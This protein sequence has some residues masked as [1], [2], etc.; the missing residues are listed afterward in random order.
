VEEEEQL[1]RA[2]VVRRRR[3]VE[4]AGDL[5]DPLHLFPARGAVE[6]LVERFQKR[7]E[8]AIRHRMEKLSHTS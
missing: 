3:R 6:V 8:R 2:R 7:F 1:E 4:A 5:R